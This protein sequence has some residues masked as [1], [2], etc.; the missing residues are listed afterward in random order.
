MSDRDTRVARLAERDKT[1]LKEMLSNELGDTYSE[2]VPEN[3]IN[4]FLR[5]AFER[6]HPNADPLS[7]AQSHEDFD[8]SW[9]PKRRLAT[10]LRMLLADYGVRRPGTP[11]M[12]LDRDTLA[13]LIVAIRLQDEGVSPSEDEREVTV[14]PE[15]PQPAGSEFSN[16]LSLADVDQKQ[17]QDWVEN[18]TSLGN[19]N[20]AVY[21]LDCTPPIG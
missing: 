17:I 6:I 9:R 8:D 14:P 2:P 11:L 12:S 15:R 16:R 13:Q 5:A 19:A 1:R 20:Y 4:S 18:R 10:A 21:V 3:L 7:V